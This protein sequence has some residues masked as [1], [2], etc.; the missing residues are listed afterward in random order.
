MAEGAIARLNGLLVEGSALP[1]QVRFADSTAARGFKQAFSN[2]ITPP[3]IPPPTNAPWPYQLPLFA[4]PING[5][6]L[7]PPLVQ[8]RSLPPAFFP[9]AV[10]GQFWPPQHFSAPAASAGP[11]P[12]P[13]FLAMPRSPSPVRL[14]KAPAHTALGIRSSGSSGASSSAP[15]LPPSRTLSSDLR[16]TTSFD[17][18][19]SR[20]ISRAPSP[21]LL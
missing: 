15:G 20:P 5:P 1:L 12:T 7:P 16:R 3:A 14:V 19:P 17:S 6:P 8:T 21:R 2:G 13:P 10:S 9:P 11:L 4:P 18:I